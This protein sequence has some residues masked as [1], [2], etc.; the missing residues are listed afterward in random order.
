MSED[1]PAVMRN[2]TRTKE[3][4]FARFTPWAEEQFA[5]CPIFQG[6]DFDFT[7]SEL[8]P[9]SEYVGNVTAGLEKMDVCDQDL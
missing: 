6:A 4:V 8:P 3:C 9:L 2:G 1:K 7:F 5:R